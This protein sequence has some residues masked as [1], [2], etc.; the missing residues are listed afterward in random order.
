MKRGREEKE[1]EKGERE[2]NLSLLSFSSLTCS[3]D[4]VI[5]A[6]CAS[7]NALASSLDVPPIPH[8]TSRIRFT[9]GRP[10]S[11][12]PD[13]SSIFSTK[14]TLALLKSLRR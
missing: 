10:A 5:P 7:G 11:L 1:K 13:H 12:T 2:K 14:F 9:A 3:V 6:T 8:P 4:S